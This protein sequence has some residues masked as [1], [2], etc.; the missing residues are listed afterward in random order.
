M[1]S[2]DEI[3]SAIDIVRNDRNEVTWD[4]ASAKRYRDATQI[5]IDLAQSYLDIKGFPDERYCASCDSPDENC[6]CDSFNEALR[7]CKLV[8]IKKE[9]EFVDE[10]KRLYGEIY[11]KNQ[12]LSTLKSRFDEG[13]I[14]KVLNELEN[15]GDMVIIEDVKIISHAIVEYLKGL[16]K[17]KGVK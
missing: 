9:A 6:D 7:L 12:E 11:D 2:S 1:P 8:W 15:K 10:I 3:R 4:G 17:R 14:E 16:D 13:E 5:L